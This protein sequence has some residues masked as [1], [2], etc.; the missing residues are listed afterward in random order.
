[1]TT[2]PAATRTDVLVVGAGPAGSECAI[3]L[4]KR[5]FEAVHLVDAASEIGGKLR[6]IRQLPTLGDWGRITDYRSIQLEKLSNVEVITNTTMTAADVREYGAQLVVVAT[7]SCWR[8]DGGQPEAPP[9]NGADASEAQVMTP[10]Q[11]MVDGKRPTGKRVTVY[12]SDGYFTA[13]GIAEFLMKEGFDVEL[14]TSHRVVSPISDGTLEG[15]MLR[16]HLHRVGVHIHRGV[17]A[18]DFSSGVLS[19]VDEFDQPWQTATD[20]L[21]LVTQQES[22]DSLYHQLSSDQDALAEAGIEGVYRVGDAVAPR[23][24]SEAVFDGHR[25]AREIDSAEPASPAP[26]LRERPGR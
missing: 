10:E 25:L 6:W 18:S 22:L 26:Y 17:T 1:V 2:S 16:K 19:G 9:I 14:V 8:G 23:M 21:V 5:G 20:S 12:D 24:I 11:V 3:V 7:G 15:S 13:P 4:A